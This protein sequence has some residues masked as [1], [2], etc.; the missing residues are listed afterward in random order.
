MNRIRKF[1]SEWFSEGRE[2]TL[3]DEFVVLQFLANERDLNLGQLAHMTG[4]SESH[5]RKTLKSL[6]KQG[7]VHAEYAM[8]REHRDNER[9]RITYKGNTFYM[10][11]GPTS[12]RTA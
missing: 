7:L 1:L 10:A 9:Y 12:R 3:G 2:E 5:V 8:R 4:K 6:R 11:N